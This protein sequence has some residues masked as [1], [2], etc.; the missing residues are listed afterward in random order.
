M[1]WLFTPLGASL[2][3]CRISVVSS[4]SSRSVCLGKKRQVRQQ[5]QGPLTP[6][7]PGC[8]PWTRSDPGRGRRPLLQAMTHTY[9]PNVTLS[10][11][12]VWEWKRARKADK[13]AVYT[14]QR[15]ATS[16]FIKDLRLNYQQQR[17]WNYL[18]N[19]TPQVNT[20]NTIAS[21]EPTANPAP[22]PP[23]DQDSRALN[24]DM[25]DTASLR[26]SQDF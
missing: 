26:P 10:L 18:P 13:L 2:S 3:G 7:T 5:H 24:S 4:S 12:H 22:P 17:G 15:E 11:L 23:L 14:G 16:F 25:R 20:S 1:K 21:T 19:N 6:A 9:L 8:C